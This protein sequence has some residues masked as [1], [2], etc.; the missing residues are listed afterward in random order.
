MSPVPS[1]DLVIAD[2]QRP[3]TL[4]PPWLGPYYK[5]HYP[6]SDKLPH[7]EPTKSDGP[8][9]WTNKPFLST[10]GMVFIRQYLT[11]GAETWE[12]LT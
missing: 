8:A 9:V 10:R 7:S 6:F 1:G 3:E 2:N 11:S 12:G 4:P 5:A